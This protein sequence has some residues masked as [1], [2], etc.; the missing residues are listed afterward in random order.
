MA[1]ARAHA[2]DFAH[3]GVYWPGGTC[4]FSQ[5]F[6]G[7]DL[8]NVKHF[9][10]GLCRCEDVGQRTVAARRLRDAQPEGYDIQIVPEFM[11]EE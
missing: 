4:P 6:E 2:Q 3:L 5:I 9:E 1:D 10:E 7:F 11:R 8:T